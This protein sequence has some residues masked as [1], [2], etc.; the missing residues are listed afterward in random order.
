MAPVFVA[1]GVILAAVL[2]CGL[3]RLACPV[4]KRH[5][6]I[7]GLN[8]VVSAC[9]AIWLLLPYTAKGTFERLLI[10]PVP[11]SVELIGHEGRV[12]VAGGWEDLTFRISPGGFDEILNSRVFVPYIVNSADSHAF[13][14]LEVW[15]QERAKNYGIEPAVVYKCGTNDYNFLLLFVK[16]DRSMAYLFRFRM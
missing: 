13:E 14:D 8:G 9:L 6:I 5:G 3:K 16:P 7:I 12:H 11:E 1:G 2:W 10:K 15:A 4:W